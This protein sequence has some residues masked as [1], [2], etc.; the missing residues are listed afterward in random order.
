[1]KP[2]RYL[3]DTARRLFRLPASGAQIDRELR[4]EFEFHIDERI[5]QLVA[6]GCSRDNA[7]REVQTR[8]GD[9]ATYLQD[10]RSIDEET[11]NQNRR[12]EFLALLSNELKRAA[13]SLRRT[14]L[15]S[16]VAIFTLVVGIGATTAIFTVLD[17]VVLR[18]LPYRE[19]QQLVSVLHPATVPGSGERKWGLSTGGYFRFRDTNHTLSD[20]GLYLASEY[21][22][23][24]GGQA[25]LARVAVATSSVFTTLRARAVMGRLI[26]DSDDSPGQPQVA[27]LSHEYFEKRFGGD[28]S[29]IGRNLET[30]SGNFEIVGVAEPGLTLPMPG[31]FSTH[32][33]LAGFGVDVWTAMQLNPAGPFYNSHPYV[34]VGRLRDG[35]TVADAQ[36]DLSQIMSHFTEVMPDAYSPEFMKEYNFRTEV[37]DL[38]NAVLGPTIPRALWMLLGSVALVLLIAAANV[39]NL[40]IVRMESR[41]RE[42]AIR[43]AM[44]ASWRH[45]A[46]HHLAE[47]WLIC[48]TAALLGVALALAGVRALLAIAPTTIPRLNAVAVNGTSVILAVAIALVLGTL[49]GLMP[50]LRPFTAAALREGG[51][52]LSASPKQRAIRNGLVI[53][54]V[55]L[56]VV[57]M[58]AAGLMMQSFLHLRGVRPGFDASNTT[59]FDM[60]LPFTE[61]DTREKALV[62]H[63]ELQ[64][65]IGEIPGV[66][67][68]GMGSELP[69]EG[70]GTG[71]SVVFRENRP[72]LSGE[73]TPCVTTVI[74]APG[75]FETMRIPVEGRA[76]A[77]SDIDNRSQAAVI[78]QA[79]A[80]RLWPGESPIGKGIASNGSDATVWYRIVG[81]VSGL[82]GETLEGAP[83]EA[84]F[85]AATG[86]RADVRDGSVNDLT[87][88]I[89][90]AN[91]P[92]PALMAQV[93]TIVHSMNARVPVVNARSMQQVVERSMSRTSFI[94]ILLAIAAAV[95][96]TL[97]A[98]GIYGVISYLV[99]QRRSEIGI[100]IALGAGVGRVAQLIVWQSVR[101]ALLGVLVGVVG[102][103]A[104]GR[105]MTSLLFG[106]SSGDTK[107]L[108]VVSLL[109]VLVA[110]AAS[111]APAR[112]AAQID[113]LEA[114]R[115]D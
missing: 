51:R 69:L 57:L 70:F 27:V 67:T 7:T 108:G 86:L 72:F 58:A 80:E 94:M 36:R 41:R 96:L 23:T 76:A 65:Q 28:A 102:A 105:L 90:T 4:E 53:G 79:L 113:P 111:L 61:F 75:F 68:V 12:F 31:P 45:L 95:A 9:Y 34:G 35:A 16:T 46:A 71:C 98:V 15:F 104:L 18:P 74:A 49:F 78:T 50:L 13:R 115:P 39:A 55:S 84:V 97:S 54:Q 32:A 93:N 26:L 10:T 1:M 48:M 88:V 101:L 87:Y 60:S 92:T 59:A 40:F 33:N 25:D 89:R 66:V 107:T 100:R 82:R 24:N 19:P 112:R 29:I 42:S 77:W 81:M 91:A 103:F 47:S 20:L 22:V 73:L 6:Q 85:Y 5:D 99:A 3:P 62:F 114:M 56:A 109:L 52:G 21:T 8:F 38:R 37:S 106:I 83:T 14:P 43:A 11:M 2:L 64:R 30:S 17:A 110:A 44:G 63:R